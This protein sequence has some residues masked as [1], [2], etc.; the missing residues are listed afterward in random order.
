MEV[1]QERNEKR[2][3]YVIRQ[4]R[5]EDLPSVIYINRTCLPENY[6]PDFFLYHFRE[7]PEGFLVAE[8]DGSIVGYIMTRIDRGVSY[9]PYLATLKEKGHIISLA[10]MP[11]ARRRGI[12]ESLLRSALE[13]IKKKG[14][15]EVYLEVRISNTPAI[16]LYKKLGFRIAKR[17]PRYYADGEDA[18]V[19]L[20]QMNSS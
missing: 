12:A 13:A 1:L 14:I 8:M 15:K 20:L 17:V 18:Y 5:E 6:T 19:M 3:E 4:F 16:N 2:Q 7:F 11:H 10:V 9:Y